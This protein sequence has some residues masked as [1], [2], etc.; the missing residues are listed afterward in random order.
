MFDSITQMFGSNTQIII[1]GLITQM[2]GCRVFFTLF[3]PWVYGRLSKP[4]DCK[5]N[6]EVFDNIRDKDFLKKR[7][8]TSMHVCR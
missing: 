3:H 5:L 1:T 7:P 6:S 2:I 8:K 4:K